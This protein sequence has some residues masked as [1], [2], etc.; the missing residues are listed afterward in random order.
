M[1]H[2]V[3]LACTFVTVLAFESSTCAAKAS[4]NFPASD[5]VFDLYFQLLFP[6]SGKIAIMTAYASR[7]FTCQV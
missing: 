6:M 4:S 3:L 5:A 7:R 1:A 2:G